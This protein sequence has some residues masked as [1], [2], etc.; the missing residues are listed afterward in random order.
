M[1]LVNL[2]IAVA[3]VI[4]RVNAEKE[5]TEILHPNPGSIFGCV[6]RD[7]N[8]ECKEKHN[9][10][11][12]C[13]SD[14]GVDVNCKLER[15]D[16]GSYI[17]RI[18]ATPTIVVAELRRLLELLM[19]GKIVQHVDITPTVVKFLFSREEINIMRTV[20]GETGAYIHLDKH[21]LHIK[22]FSSLDNVDRAEQRFI[23][24]LLALHE[25][26]QLEVHLR[27]GLLPPDL[28]KRVVI[29]FGP[30]LSIVKEK[31]PREEFSLNTK[32]HCICI[33]GDE[34]HCVVCL[35]ELDDPYRLKACTH[36]FCRSC[37]LEQ[38]ESAIK[39]REG[40]PMCCL[41]SG[42]GEPFLLADLKSLLST[43]KLEELFKA[44]LGAF[45]TANAGTYRFCPSPYSHSIYCITA[46]AMR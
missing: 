21:S 9:G 42:C 29:T 4:N 11:G 16:N 17:V 37:L 30:D 31:V 10:T 46:S 45:V 7:C 24:S 28:M 5:C 22:I 27:G 39:S 18:S 36:E 25:S 44:S 26:K 14:G 15:N 35:C 19:R 41:R 38:C 33:N 34:A 40:F 6:L 8:K 32:R 13:K 1:L 20:H 43:E 12:Y 23:D 2:I 3:L